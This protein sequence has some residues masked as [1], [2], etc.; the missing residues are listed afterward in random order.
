MDTESRSRTEKEGGKGKLKTI[1]FNSMDALQRTYQDYDSPFY[2]TRNSPNGNALFPCAPVGIECFEDFV[3]CGE[4]SFIP[5]FFGNTDEI[6]EELELW[7][8]SLEL[9][10][11]DD[12]WESLRIQV[13]MNVGIWAHF[14]AYGSDDEIWVIA[15]KEYK[16]LRRKDGWAPSPEWQG[17]GSAKE[18][19]EG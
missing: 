2:Y 12:D 9:I 4:A 6:W 10:R 15:G 1:V 13:D 11:R 3:R 14:S 8:P 17:Q 19:G 7:A 5:A 18:E 16:G